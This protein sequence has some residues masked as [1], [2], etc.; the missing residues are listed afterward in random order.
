MNHVD[1]IHK[2]ILVLS[3]FVDEIRSRIGAL[4]QR[5]FYTIAKIDLPNFIITS[6]KSEENY[7]YIVFSKKER[8][9]IFLNSIKDGQVYF[10]NAKSVFHKEWVDE[11]NEKYKK[12][13]K[14]INKIYDKESELLNLVNVV[15]QEIKQ[16]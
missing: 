16:L 11:L 9:E 7:G 13:T 5:Q 4:G 15:S 14:K 1:E 2:N 12:L 8:K 6:F 10:F 3:R